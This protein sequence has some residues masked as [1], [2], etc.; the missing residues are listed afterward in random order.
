MTAF[1]LTDNDGQIKDRDMLDLY[2]GYLELCLPVKMFKESDLHCNQSLISKEDIFGGHVDIC[3][4]IWRNLKVAEPFVSCYPPLLQSFFERTIRQTTLESFYKTLEENKDFGTEYFV[5]PVKNKVF[6]GY[7]CITPQDLDKLQCSKKTEV[8]VSS[9]VKF[10]AEFRAYIYKDKIVDAFRYWGDDWSA[11]FDRSIV[12]AM[13][14]ALAGTMPVF[15]SLDFGTSEGKTLLV[16]VNDGYAL[17]NYGL[18]P[19]PYAEMTIARWKEILC[20]TTSNP[21]VVSS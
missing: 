4:I 18:A 11:V 10:G 21:I 12:E 2:D 3:R 16:E 7:T 8:Y 17:G 5:K 1:V 14:L 13:V 19:K 9:Y 6:T 15:Y 20:L